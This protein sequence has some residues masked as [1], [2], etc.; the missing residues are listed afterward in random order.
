MLP[1]PAPAECGEGIPPELIPGEVG[2]DRP[3]E[4]MDME[5]GPPPV[6]IMGGWLKP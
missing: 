1:P 5:E 4:D 2:L 3:G 6:L